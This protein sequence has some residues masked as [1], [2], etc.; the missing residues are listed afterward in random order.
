MIS[1]YFFLLSFL[2]Q[3]TALVFFSFL[4]FTCEYLLILLNESTCS[5]ESRLY[6]EH[7]FES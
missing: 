6:Q 2:L 3:N 1:S 7:N 4:R 5:N